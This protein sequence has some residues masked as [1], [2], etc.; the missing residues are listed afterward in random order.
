MDLLN[1]NVR[2]L[3]LRYLAA[4]LGQTVVFALL[5]GYL[6]QKRSNLRVDRAA[7]RI[8]VVKRVSKIVAMGASTFVIDLAMGV[9]TMIFNMQTLALGGEAGL[10]VWGMVSSVSTTTQTFCY[11]TGESAQAILPWMPWRWALSLRLSTFVFLRPLRA[12]TWT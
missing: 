2:S 8:G 9:M 6:F 1:D 4:A 10:A 3:Y 5:V 12:C 11:A 7:L